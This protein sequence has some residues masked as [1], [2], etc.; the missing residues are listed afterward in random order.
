MTPGCD[1][2]TFHV[3]HV[4]GMDVQTFSYQAIPLSLDDSAHPE[5]HTYFYKE[6]KGAEYNGKK[7]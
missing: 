5:L 2:D 1:C 6:K 3:S 7:L 4:R